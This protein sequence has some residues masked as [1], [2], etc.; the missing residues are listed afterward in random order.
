MLLPVFS[1][2]CAVPIKLNTL[3]TTEHFQYFQAGE[4]LE[5][6]CSAT[7][8]NFDK[9]IIADEVTPPDLIETN[10]GLK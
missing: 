2:P 8:I 3:A 1:L 5:T 4:E 6:V 7:P 9:R 10:L